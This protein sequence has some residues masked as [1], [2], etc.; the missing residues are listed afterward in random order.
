MSKNKTYIYPHTSG[1][2]RIIQLS[3]KSKGMS[4]KELAAASGVSRPYISQMEAGKR[5]PTIDVLYV[6]ATVIEKPIE[7]LLASAEHAPLN[8]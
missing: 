4:T 2:G 5:L 6:I 3:R 1:L 7:F 8:K